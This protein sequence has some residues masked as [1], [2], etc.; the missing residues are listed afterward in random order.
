MQ[1]FEDVSMRQPWRRQRRKGRQGAGESS[2]SSCA[3][4]S[5]AEGRVQAKQTERVEDS[6]LVADGEVQVVEKREKED[7]KRLV[8]ARKGIKA[9]EETTSTKKRTPSEKKALARGRE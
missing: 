9:S 5:E 6:T 4:C 8:N 3:L 2:C 7:V 1:R